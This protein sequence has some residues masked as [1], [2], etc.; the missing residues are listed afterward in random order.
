MG[1][2]LLSHRLARLPQASGSVCGL[3]AAS[4]LSLINNPSLACLGPQSLLR[5]EVWGPRNAKQGP[6]GAKVGS[7]CRGLG[8]TGAKRWENTAGKLFTATNCQGSL[9]NLRSLFLVQL[10]NNYLFFFFL[11]PIC[12]CP[13]LRKKVIKSYKGNMNLGI[14]LPAQPQPMS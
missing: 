1:P 4:H 14:K 6:V 10:K 8:C 7:E 11:H 9:G 2:S 13:L 12:K 5:G 3:R